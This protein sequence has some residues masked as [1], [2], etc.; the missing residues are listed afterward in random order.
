[1]HQESMKQMMQEDIN[2]E[3]WEKKK[4]TTQWVKDGRKEVTNKRRKE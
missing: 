2:E 4:G 3:K 1:M